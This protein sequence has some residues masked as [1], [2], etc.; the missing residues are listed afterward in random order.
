MIKVEFAIIVAKQ[1]LIMFF[2]I[3]LGII[4]CRK[5]ILSL[6]AT[7]G[8]SDFI[9]IIVS[10]C[11]LISSFQRQI[12]SNE[13]KGLILAF[14]LSFIFNAMAVVISNLL[15]RKREDSNYR[16]ERMGGVYSNCGFM[17]FP[18][19][20][21]VLGDVGVF[22]GAVYVTV[23]NIFLWSSGVITLTSYSEINK[24]KILFNPGTIATFIG[25]VLY[26]TQIH[27]PEVLSQTITYVANLNTPLSMIMIGVFL[28][29]VDVKETISDIRIYF[30]SIIRLIVLPIIL[31]LLV[32]ITGVV[33]LFDG[34]KT[35]T[36]AITI[37]SACPAAVSVILMVSKMKLNDTYGARILA[38]STLLSLITLP[39][40]TLLAISI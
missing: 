11:L 13:V 27:V 6:E 23:F 21:M 14:I 17:A 26:F 24:L 34:A 28:A 39:L 22:Y 29:R 5:N 37:C 20:A 38:L 12:D 31:L 1:V 30:V 35:A 33:G 18:L 9:L 40:I 32:K 7:R 2:L 15:I 8:L 19:L 10:P 3:S 16:V 25:L 4:V 36:I